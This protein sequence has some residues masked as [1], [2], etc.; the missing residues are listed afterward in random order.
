MLG[1]AM[2][3][4][5]P[6][7]GERSA[8][9]RSPHRTRFAAGLA[10]L[11]CATLLGAQSP[12]EIRFPD[13]KVVEVIGLRRWTI[14]MIQDSLARYSPADSLQSHACA[15]VLR[16]KL[17]FADAST[18]YF[19]PRPG[20]FRIVVTVREPQDSARVKYRH[21]QFDTTGG[22]AEWADVR[23]VLAQKTGLF[24]DATRSLFLGGPRNP[25][26]RLRATPDSSEVIQLASW[27]R[28][29]TSDKDRTTALHV[30]AHA[31]NM[32]DRTIA[33]I[34]LANFPERDDTWYAL[35]DALLEPDYSPKVFAS[36]VLTTLSERGRR[37]VDWTPRYAALNSILDGTSLFHAGDVMEMLVY[38]GAGPAQARALLKNGGTLLLDYLGSGTPLLAYRSHELLVK[39][40]GE[41]LGSSPEPWRQWIASL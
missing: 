19:V 16:Y 18:T 33:T 21:V 17:H 25:P 20:E 6:M 15:S 30:L 11:V 14:A 27:F 3:A 38:T 39:L 37:A 26:S 22:L 31:P 13:G 29:R 28:L 36:L 35:V 10:A 41:D 12:A 34:V 1:P 2:S 8:V 32:L 40:R 23:A 9:T 7:I 24:E 5:N 4:H